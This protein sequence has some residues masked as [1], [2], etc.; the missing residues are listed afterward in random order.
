[1]IGAK[2]SL[3]AAVETLSLSGGRQPRCP[4]H[5]VLLSTTLAPS[6][7]EPFYTRSY[8]LLRGTVFSCNAGVVNVAKKKKQTIK[9]RN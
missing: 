4:L 5:W 3:Y 7:S 1:M 2:H 9:I 8:D 6:S